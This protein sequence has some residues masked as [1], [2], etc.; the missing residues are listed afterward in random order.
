MIRGLPADTVASGTSARLTAGDRESPLGLIRSGAPAAGS[1][2]EQ[3]TGAI[4]RRHQY[5]AGPTA[6]YHRADRQ[7]GRQGSPGEL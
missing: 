3:V 4:G 6:P 7:I 1:G 2:H 5:Q